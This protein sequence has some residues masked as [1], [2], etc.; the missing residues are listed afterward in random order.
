MMQLTMLGVRDPQYSADLP[1][2]MHMDMA[3]VPCLHQRVFNA[4]SGR[5]PKNA[6]RTPRCL[7]YPH[8]FSVN[9]HYFHK[10]YVPGYGSGMT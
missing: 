2:A 1:F 5:S 10:R 4:H 6:S 9:N 8:I 3:R 7:M